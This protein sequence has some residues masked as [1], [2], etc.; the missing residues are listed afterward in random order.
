MIDEKKQICAGPKTGIYV[1]DKLFKPDAILDNGILIPYTDKQIVETA[2]LSHDGY[3]E[4]YSLQVPAE[5]VTFDM[6]M[7]LNEESLVAGS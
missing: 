3:S 7:L 2:I 6:S 4:L 1:A 5:Q